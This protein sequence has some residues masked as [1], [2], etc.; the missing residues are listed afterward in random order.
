MIAIQR[1]VCMFSLGPLYYPGLLRNNRLFLIQ[2]LNPN[3]V[4]YP[5]QLMNLLGSVVF[6]RI[7]IYLYHSLLYYVIIKGLSLLPLIPFF[8]PAPNTQ[9]LMITLSGN[10]CLTR[11]L[12]FI[13]FLLRIS[14]PIFSQ[15][16]FASVVSFSSVQA[17]HHLSTV[18]LEGVKF[19]IFPDSLAPFFFAISSPLLHIRKL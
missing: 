3:I 16:L 8:I 2:V 9:K 10:V 17:Q 12:L 19:Y 13:I 4:L 5:L 6:S 15:K 18:E 14:L 11:I 7:Y 1:V